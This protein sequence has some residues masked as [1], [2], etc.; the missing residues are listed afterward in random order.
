[1][2]VLVPE[3]FI[4]Y[5]KHQKKYI[6]TVQ[7]VMMVKTSHILSL[8]IHKVVLVETHQTKEISVKMCIY[9][10]V[11]VCIHMYMCVCVYSHTL[12]IIYH[13]FIVKFAQVSITNLIFFLIQPDLEGKEKV[14]D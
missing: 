11:C 4:P 9:L 2:Q 1:M 10:S 8:G 5:D 6:V 7:T 14:F 13:I 3:A 12:F